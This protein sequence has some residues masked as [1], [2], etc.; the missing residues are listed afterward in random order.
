VSCGVGCRRGSDPALWLWLTP[1]ATAPI[2][3][4][5]WEPPYAVGT[6]LKRQKKKIKVIKASKKGLN[7]NCQSFHCGTMRLGLGSAGTQ[8]PP[9]A[10]HSGLRIQHCHSCGLGL[11]CDSD[12]IPCLRTLYAVDWPKKEKNNQNINCHM[13]QQFHF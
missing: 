8:V 6:A 9:P 1:E 2:R 7:I 5:A 12:L 11:D 3:P 10:R 13:N 4:L